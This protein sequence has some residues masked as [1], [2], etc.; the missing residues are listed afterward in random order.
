MARLFN[1]AV[2]DYLSV[3]SA[4]A[5]AAPLTMAAW[6]K[7][8]DDTKAQ[9]ALWIGNS[10]S[11]QAFYID[12]RGNVAGDHVRAGSNDGADATAVSTTGF[13]ANTWCHVAGVFTSTTS[14]TIYLDGGG[15]ATDTTAITPTVNQFGIGRQFRP[16]GGDD[17]SGMIAEVGIWSAA[18]DA[19]EIA[20][21]AKGICPLLIRPQSLVGYWPLFGNDATEIDRWRN[22]YV[23]TVNGAVKAEHPRLYY[24]Q[25]MCG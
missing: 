7:S 6:V 19:S 17:F 9:A 15:S 5:T 1:D 12:L 24:P 11:G 16:G 25:V 10:A 4:P 18:L 3:A 2:N 23:L 20:A 21:L 14:R 8:D 22:N 13:V